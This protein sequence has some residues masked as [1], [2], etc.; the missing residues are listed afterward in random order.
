MDFI[1]P[2]FLS[3]DARRRA[4]GLSKPPIERQLH[5]MTSPSRPLVATGGGADLLHTPLA[6]DD[7]NDI[8]SP[9]QC[10]QDLAKCLDGYH[11]GSPRAPRER[12]SLRWPTGPKTL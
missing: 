7:G 8:A 3:A 4:P 11:R 6:A 1:D 12:L 5:R 2:A 9:D 10:R